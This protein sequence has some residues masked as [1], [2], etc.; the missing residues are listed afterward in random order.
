[1]C[2]YNRLMGLEMKIKMLF[3]SRHKASLL[4]TRRH[5]SSLI[6]GINL[7]CF[8]VYGSVTELASAMWAKCTQ[9]SMKWT[10]PQDKNEELGH[11]WWT[12]HRV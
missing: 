2:Q 5:A 12:C 9:K 6:V 7:G 4:F 10:K 11:I 1:M 3:L 8:G